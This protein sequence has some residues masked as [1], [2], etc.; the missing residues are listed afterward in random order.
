MNKLFLIVLVSFWAAQSFCDE[1]EVDNL[2]LCEADL[3]T[4][5]S[6][7]NYNTGTV[8]LYKQIPNGFILRKITRPF[9]VSAPTVV[10][11]EVCVAL[12]K[13]K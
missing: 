10:A 9:S 7:V 12:N 1:N 2:I 8:Q 5:M 11:G 3:A 4:V 6:E 13:V